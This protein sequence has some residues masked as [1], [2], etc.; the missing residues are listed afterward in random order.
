MLLFENWIITSIFV[1]SKIALVTVLQ[2][3]WNKLQQMEKDMKNNERKLLFLDLFL[4]WVSDLVETRSNLAH[5]DGLL[6]QPTF[7]CG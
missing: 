4:S 1:H 5:D 7:Q 3:Q 6:S 2:M